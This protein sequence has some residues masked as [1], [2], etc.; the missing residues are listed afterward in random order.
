MTLTADGFVWRALLTGTAPGGR[1]R[2]HTCAVVTLSDT[3]R[4]ARTDEY[5]DPAGLAPLTT[6]AV[7]TAVR[8]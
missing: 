2:A 6:A 4:V 3:G 7:A 1:L 8:R 5:L